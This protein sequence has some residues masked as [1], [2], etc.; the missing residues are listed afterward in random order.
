MAWI[1]VVAVALSFG[2]IGAVVPVAAVVLLGEFVGGSVIGLGAGLGVR[3]L[4]D[5]K[6]R[7]RGPSES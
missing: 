4:L 6:R 1:P 7:R 5:G 2:P 3:D